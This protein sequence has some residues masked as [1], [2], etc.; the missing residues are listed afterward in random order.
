MENIEK[1][2]LDCNSYIKSKTDEPF[3]FGGSCGLYLQNILLDRDIHDID[4]RFI[5]MPYKKATD[6]NLKFQPKIDIL[7]DFRPEEPDIKEIQLSGTTILVESVESIV[8]AKKK[9]LDFFQNK[10]KI[11]DDW[12]LKQKEKAIR[13]LKYI[14]EKYN[15]T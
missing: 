7:I 8:D 2:I 12:R 5:S 10:A 4:I 3:A 1:L 15:I 9:M 14:K 13:D 11:M 6:L